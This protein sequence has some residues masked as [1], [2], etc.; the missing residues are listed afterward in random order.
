[1]T[2]LAII[3]GTVTRLDVEAGDETETDERF[4]KAVQECVEFGAHDPLAAVSA[5]VCAAF[6]RS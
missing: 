1:M 5:V 4:R 2:A 3:E 6:T